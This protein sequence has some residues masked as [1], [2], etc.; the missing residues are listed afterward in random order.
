MKQVVEVVVDKI[1]HLPARR[2]EL[3]LSCGHIQVIVHHLDPGW[4]KSSRAK[5]VPKK[6]RCRKCERGY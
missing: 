1:V 5:E 4:E 2:L 6:E 3:K